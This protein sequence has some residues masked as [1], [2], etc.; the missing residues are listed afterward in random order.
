MKN[1]IILVAALTLQSLTT[2]VIAQTPDD[3]VNAVAAALP[4]I[5]TKVPAGP[6]ALVYNDWS[7]ALSKRLA[8]KI[9]KSIE[10]ES[11]K[12]ACREDTNTHN[13]HCSLSGVSSL[14]NLGSVRI[15]GENARVIFSIE[16]PSGSS[17]EPIEHEAFAVDLRRSGSRWT[18]VQVRSIA[19][20]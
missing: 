10:H 12:L 14:I 7:A 1:P 15:S 3:D 6:T 18:V 13:K 5:M 8:A 20:S 2:G 9:G 16:R 17:N 11:S 4:A 19:I